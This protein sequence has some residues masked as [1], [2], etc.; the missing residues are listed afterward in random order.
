[1]TAAGARPGQFTSSPPQGPPRPTVHGH[2]PAVPGVPQSVTGRRAARQ[3]GYRPVTV[4]ADSR[5]PSGNLN[6]NRASDQLE[7]GP[8]SGQARGPGPLK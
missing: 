2:G 1:M 5:S 4:A 6:L 8:A 7:A 3:P